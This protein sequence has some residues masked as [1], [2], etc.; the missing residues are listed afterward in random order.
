MEIDNFGIFREHLDFVD[1]K[2]DRY[3]IH[4]LRRPKD[5]SAQMKNELGANESQ[6]LI[7]TYYVDSIE[8]F[9]RKIPAIKELCVANNAR[10][11][12]IV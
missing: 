7:K 8:Y 12:I 6:R 10:V 2:L 11:H 1:T 5:L 9:D 3:V 4:I